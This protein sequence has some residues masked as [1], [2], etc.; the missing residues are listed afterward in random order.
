VPP[1]E[2]RIQHIARSQPVEDAVFR[3]STLV[4]RDDLVVEWRWSRNR[5]IGVK[6][7]IPLTITA[8]IVTGLFAP[9][10]FP[11]ALAVGGAATLYFA[12]CWL[13]DRTRLTVTANII[14]L[15]HRPLP[16]PGGWRLRTDEIR[17]L[18]VECLNLGDD[19]E[20]PVLEYALTALDHQ[21][22]MRRLARFDDQAEVDL[23]M[24][25]LEELLGLPV[26]PVAGELP[27]G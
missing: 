16:V 2:L 26:A 13:F 19:D 8:G 24:R 12:A 9:A 17:Q 3:A 10:A 20:G 15:R 27:P 11:A 21:G 5:G 18:F 7:T 6:T 4:V 25:T 23:L 14:E 22:R 1:P